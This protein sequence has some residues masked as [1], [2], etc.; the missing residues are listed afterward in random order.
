[1]A[2]QRLNRLDILRAIAIL[3]VLGRHMYVAMFW[4][5][6]GWMGVDL[7]FVLS[8][9]LVSGLL[10]S[11]HQ[12]YGQL[13]VVRFWVR[14]AFKIYPAFYFLLLVS[15]I[16]G[17]HQQGWLLAD[18]FFFQNYVPGW[19]HHTWSLAVE[20]HFYLMAPLLL[21]L[22][23]RAGRGQK[24]PFVRLPL[25]VGALAVIALAL[26]L[27]AFVGVRWQDDPDFVFRQWQTHLRIDSLAIGVLVSYFYR[28]RPEV[29]AALSRRHLAAIA[30]AAALLIVPCTLS[31]IE[32]SIP[33]ATVGY[34]ALYLGFAGVLVLFLQW[35]QIAP[36]TSWL[37]KIGAGLGYIGRHSY[38]IYLWHL[39]VRLAMRALTDRYALRVPNV[40]AFGVYVLVSVVVGVVLAKVIEWPAL[41]LRDRVFPSRT[42]SPGA[43][44]ADLTPAS[45]SA[46]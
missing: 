10:F 44:R 42:A 33:I 29:I 15:A 21:A 36:E 28:Y 35:P 2:T 5:R 43:P 31:D 23:A 46:P 9:F 6:M 8:G 37:G 24:D 45:V 16:T 7:F 41:R 1:L 18:V 38:S 14:R 25:Y 26:R 13:N 12:K 34:A 3:M 30:V 22:I 11:E 4:M 19:W 32:R 40:V 27:H 20:E 17:F 39:P